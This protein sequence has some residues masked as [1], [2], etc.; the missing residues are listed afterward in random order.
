MSVNNRINAVA[1][2]TVCF[3]RFTS[4][5][6]LVLIN[7]NLFKACLH[8]LIDTTSMFTY[9]YKKHEEIFPDI[10]LFN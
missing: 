1:I 10:I 5:C 2:K 4:F 9:F 7:F 3:P 6:A 8:K